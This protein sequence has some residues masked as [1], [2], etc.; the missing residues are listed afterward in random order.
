MPARRLRAVS[1]RGPDPALTPDSGL[2]FWDSGFGFWDS[3]FRGSG[4]GFWDSGF[5][6]PGFWDLDSDSG[7]LD[8]GVLGFCIG[9]L[10]AR[11]W[12]AG[13]KGSVRFVARATNLDFSERQAELGLILSQSTWRAIWLF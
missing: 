13:P 2:G 1:G 6:I 4:F 10:A 9:P 12:A 8:S 5:W 7:I 11:P 3:G